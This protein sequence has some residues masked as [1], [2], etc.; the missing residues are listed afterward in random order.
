MYFNDKNDFNAIED[1]WKMRK[2]EKKV[3]GEKSA[4][5]LKKIRKFRMNCKNIKLVEENQ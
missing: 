4:L 5:G 2:K 1:K 3:K